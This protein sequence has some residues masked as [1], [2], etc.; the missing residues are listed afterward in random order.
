MRHNSSVSHAAHAFPIPRGWIVLGAALM[1]WM[2][3]AAFWTGTTQ[4]FAFVSARI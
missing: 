3:V 2:L 4:L 1:S